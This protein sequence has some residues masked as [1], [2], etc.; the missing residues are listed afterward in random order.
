[1]AHLT[2]SF[3]GV[4]PSVS[5]TSIIA[6]DTDT[7]RVG[8]SS[9]MSSSALFNSTGSY[10]IAADLGSV[11]LSVVSAS[12]QIIT[13]P[14]YIDL[15]FNTEMTNG[16]SN[17]ALNI[18]SGV[19]DYQN[20]SLSP[21]SYDF[22]GYGLTPYIDDLI[23]PN[24]TDA[25]PNDNVTFKVLDVG[26]SVDSNSVHIFVQQGTGSLQEALVSGSFVA[27]FNGP[28]SSYT[29]YGN[30]YSVV[31]DPSG[32]LSFDVRIYIT[33][34]DTSFNL[35]SSS[36]GACDDPFLL[37]RRIIE[38]PEM[39]TLVLHWTFENVTGS[40]NSSDGLPTTSDAK[41]IVEDTTSGS[42]ELTNRY[43]WFGPIRYHQHPGQG[44]F[45]LPF[46]ID[47]VNVEYI[48]SAK[49]LPPEVL[50]SSNMVEIR[51]SDDDLFTR[52]TR[53][54][55]HFYAIE[56]SPYAIITDEVLKIFGTIKDF[57]N[58]IGEP[59]NRYRQEYKN[60]TQ[61]RHLYFERV[62][63]SSI[64]FEKFVDYFKWFDSS[65]SMMLQQLIP[66]SAHFSGEVRTLIESHILERNKYWNKLPTIEFKG[67]PPEGGMK[68]INELL[69]DW[70][71]GSAPVSGLQ[72]E[73]EFWWKNR[74]EKTGINS[75]G[76]TSVDISRTRIF[77]V[78]TSAL[79]RSFTTPL[80]LDASQQVTASD[81]IE[82]MRIENIKNS[83]SLFSISSSVR[84]AHI[85]L[86][87]YASDYEIVQ[88]SGRTNNNRFLTR[89]EGSQSLTL[90][91]PVLG[92]REFTL[93]DRTAY[94]SEHV[95]VEHF[96]SP[97]EQKTISRGYLDRE[98]EEYSVYNDLNYRNSLV[99][100]RLN[101]DE[102]TH[103]G[104]FGVHPTASAYAN[105]HKI[106][107][108]TSRRIEEDGSAFITASVYDNAFVQRPIPQSE[109]QYAWITSS[110]IP[111]LCP[112]GY[113]SEFYVPSGSTSVPGFDLVFISASS[114]IEGISGIRVDFA[115][116]NTLIKDSLT[117][118]INL[119]SSSEY[120][121]TLFG[122]I[123]E[124][125]V[126]NKLLLHR[127][128]PY[129]Y[130]SWKQ[131]RTGEHPIARKHRETNILSV[132]DPTKERLITTNTGQ[133]IPYK[134]RRSDTFTNYE[135][136][137]VVFRNRPMI[138]TLNVKGSN[139][140]VSLRHSYSN[141]IGMFANTDLNNKL[142]LSKCDDQMYDRIKELYIDADQN[143]LENP[144]DG[145]LS[146]QYSEV[147]YPKEINTG[148]KIIRGRT[149][150]AEDASVSGTFVYNFYDSN[151]ALVL[152][153][154]SSASYGHNGIDRNPL[155]RRTFWRNDPKKR[156]RFGLIDGH[157]EEGSYI[158]RSGSLTT[159][160]INSQGI[161]DGDAPSLWPFGIE[162][163]HTQSYEY[164]DGNSK[165]MGKW[166]NYDSGELS[167]DRTI[168]EV[169]LPPPT[170]AVRDWFYI[171]R[172]ASA[173]AD[174]GS[175]SHFYYFLHPTA[176]ALYNKPFGDLFANTYH[177]FNF[178][179]NGKSY[180]LV[181]DTYEHRFRTS[182][183]SGKNPWFDSYEEFFDDIKSLSKDYSIIPEFNISQNMDFYVNKQGGNFRKSNNKFLS[184][185]GAFITQ[186]AT[187]E[188]SGLDET[189]FK[190]FS[191]SD[192]MKHYDV[193]Y[194]DHNDID[195][196]VERITLK[197]KGIKKLL[198][199]N[200]FY[201]VTRTVQL[202]TLFS[203]SYAPHIG[204]LYWKDGKPRD[205]SM[206]PHSGNLA[207][208]SL[209]Q[210][211]FAPGILYNTIKSGIAMDFPVFTGS[212]GDIG[213]L[214]AGANLLFYDDP[215][216]K[217]QFESL[218]D[219]KNGS[220][221]G[222]VPISSSN[223]S[224]S[225][226]WNLVEFLAGAT[227][228]PGNRRDIFFDW[229]G[230]E[231]NSLYKLSMHNFLA[232]SINFFLEGSKV[233]AII[234]KPSN[235]MRAM[236][237]GNSYYMDVKLYKSDDL[238][239]YGSRWNSTDKLF[240]TASFAYGPSGPNGAGPDS[241]E[242][243][244]DYAALTYTGRFFGHPFKWAD[245]FN[246]RATDI[247]DRLYAF[248]IAA[249][250]NAT[251]IG[252]HMRLVR[253]ADPAYAPYL[254]PY[255]FKDSVARISYKA[256]GTE[257]EKF[258]PISYVLSKANVENYNNT[259]RDFIA[260]Y[261]HDGYD[262]VP[263]RPAWQGRSTVSSS[264]N[265]FGVSKGLKVTYDTK[266][267]NTI[268]GKAAAQSIEDA[269][270][271]FNSWAI[272]PRFECPILNFK[273][274][275]TEY[276]DI[277]VDDT[278]IK[279]YQIPKGMWSG[280]GE[281]CSG[282]T[283]V[284]MSVEES[285]SN[286][287]LEEQLVTGSLI[288]VF[289]FNTEPLR[290]GEPNTGKEIAEAIVAI[291][292]I[293][294]LFK[295]DEFAVTTNV[296]GRNF[297]KID[298]TQWR[299][300]KSKIE[301]GQDAIDPTSGF[302]D[303]H[304]SET[305]I[306]KLPQQMSQYVIPPEMNFLKY[307]DIPPFVMYIFEF[308]H[309]LDKQDVVDI[310]QGVMPKIGMTSEKDEVELSHPMRP[311]EFFHGKKLPSNVRW[312]V[313]KVK[314][315]AAINY[316][317]KTADSKDDDRFKFDFKVGVK[318][319]DYSFNWPYDYFSLVELAQIEAEVT[320]APIPK[321]IPIPTPGVGGLSST[322][323]RIVPSTVAPTLNVSNQTVSS[324]IGISVGKKSVMD[325]ITVKPSIGISVFGKSTKG[326]KSSSPKGGG[327]IKF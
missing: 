174:F 276:Y 262:A 140:P 122:T 264:I 327:G 128:G 186:S 108:N 104:Q 177:D 136:P 267:F 218:L 16:S 204:G 279:R 161:R 302:G 189:F 156:N 299:T 166:G 150:H 266:S 159:P 101:I 260:F 4:G 231:S 226:Y 85:P 74:A 6:I 298:E 157:L 265:L 152:E 5:I 83:R 326:V 171:Q 39:E 37:P 290:L 127:N 47:A 29:A 81:F 134:D 32:S 124:H 10:S 24:P 217:I 213:T 90:Q 193:I 94:N 131:I 111:E 99:R 119:L 44:D 259:L 154:V 198:P 98:A 321:D 179:E 67:N 285:F 316:F 176:S 21:L 82:P 196:H 56:K 25:N 63:N 59:V 253:Y 102:S 158:V 190:T 43:S 245:D 80:H 325:S 33:A 64:D 269:D 184:N 70:K 96:S 120:K 211:F 246:D 92:G 87:N 22:N 181:Q 66:A 165:N 311:W 129:Q 242:I 320:I 215:N 315:L 283:G 105:Y 180:E 270:S 281:F 53:P 324:N 78:R 155:E 113:A 26:S 237:S 322:I 138:H 314:K 254:P 200:G 303:F 65:I 121:N 306:S 123:P 232:E 323:S 309:V 142:G 50:N 79:N 297:F 23:I 236:V 89:T 291:P 86:G 135:E 71:D 167:P 116:I 280:Y 68:S 221:R 214:G 301:A 247:A 139:T 292:F 203:Q 310:W 304:I 97:G 69:Y 60:L 300:Q 30:G 263:L 257:K 93:P 34:A 255:Y 250:G 76:I 224:G 27:P 202:A 187:T 49:Q 223:G 271:T 288:N 7:V 230:G 118:S 8:F 268:T 12:A 11:G 3:T 244:P 88:T 222:G 137:A 251:A 188:E 147:I 164:P 284:Y 106:N 289:G 18:V 57:N 15:S 191:H 172:G 219:I 207:V 58:L 55:K 240:H 229:N 275:P 2:N 201:P 168:Y 274:Q 205:S 163:Y 149:N 307:D 110:A 45:F 17:Y 243:V 46:D 169:N 77:S 183:L 62:K 241:T 182:I 238:L 216:Y 148:K 160:L 20:I 95:F 317:E 258:D 239:M 36:L 235:K 132:S 42:L 261:N 234:S 107:R 13:Y 272:S 54:V 197:C 227:N 208:M 115:G 28:S 206:N 295:D 162:L 185:V 170:F 294:N 277:I 178:S 233:K 282:S 117:A 112:I 225:I 256:D 9:P 319:P 100:N 146:L 175:G 91:T 31:I 293:D 145:F 212:Q 220:N 248:G 273:N 1:M 75:S 48:P 210:P 41:F 35:F 286:L 209:L 278:A 109:L 130:P 114:D 173:S 51:T 252:S 153:N 305:S 103:A 195:N 133:R 312:L 192:I 296:M 84:N 287:T 308:K 61:L 14:T 313:F 318:A 38:V 199:Y 126:L 141:N 19:V 144:I 40:S 73:N 125:E 151:Q 194:N 72:S 143:E 249:F 228:L 52:D